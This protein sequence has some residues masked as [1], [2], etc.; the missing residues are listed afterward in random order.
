MQM[1]PDKIREANVMNLWWADF[2]LKRVSHE[3]RIG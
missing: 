1:Y 3:I 2:A